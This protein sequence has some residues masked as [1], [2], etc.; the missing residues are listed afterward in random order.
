MSL[1]HR[2]TESRRGLSYLTSAAY[3]HTAQLASRAAFVGGALTVG[4]MAIGHVEPTLRGL[5]HNIGMSVFVTTAAGCVEIMVHRHAVMRRR[6]LIAATAMSGG[7]SLAVAL[8]YLQKVFVDVLVA[9]CSLSDSYSAVGRVL[10]LN[11]W[12]LSSLLY[13]L[14]L[15][16]G[17]SYVGAFVLLVVA[18]IRGLD[19]VSQTG[20]VFL[21][22][23]LLTLPVELHRWMPANGF[24]SVL[25]DCAWQSLVSISFLPIFYRLADGASSRALELWA[26]SRS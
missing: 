8:G 24:V 9:T 14:S 18:R 19:L 2:L 15:Y 12:S 25:S 21:G 5:A 26:R 17:P 13:A 3:D 16:S 1:R 6:E 4:Q 20:L 7:V 23:V 22:A 11:S 10:S